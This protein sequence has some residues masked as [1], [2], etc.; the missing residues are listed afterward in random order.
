MKDINQIKQELKDFG[1]KY[2]ACK[3]GIEAIKGNNLT[4]LF[5]NINVYILV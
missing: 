2:N 5:Q 1:I 4:E 3:E